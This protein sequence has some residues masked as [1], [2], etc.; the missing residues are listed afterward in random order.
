MVLI[1][2][3]IAFP[4]VSAIILA[5][6]VTTG[7]TAM[8][9]RTINGNTSDVRVAACGFHISGGEMIK[10]TPF[11][12]FAQAF[13]GV[14]T[15]KITNVSSGGSNTTR[16]TNMFKAGVLPK[17]TIWLNR[18]S[19]LSMTMEAVDDDGKQICDMNQTIDLAELPTGI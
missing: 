13:D 14:A 5:F 10:V 4:A 11:I 9:D 12:E 19:V 15:V 18:S 3:H 6:P 7:A 16:Q 1:S 17:S 2:S 8:T